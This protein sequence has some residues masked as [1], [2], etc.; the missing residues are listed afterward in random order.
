MIDNYSIFKALSVAA[1]GYV[2]GMGLT[3]FMQ[4]LE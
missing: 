4:T 1:G 2:M 3:L